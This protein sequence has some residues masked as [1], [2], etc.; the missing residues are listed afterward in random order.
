MS[1]TVNTN[2]GV[3]AEYREVTWRLPSEHRGLA[4]PLELVTSRVSEWMAT[5]QT[6]AQRRCG[7]PPSTCTHVH[8]ADVRG[9]AYFGQ[10]GRRTATW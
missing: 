6:K 3:V 2:D 4:M 9:G 10:R 7:D 1:S 8:M 5:D